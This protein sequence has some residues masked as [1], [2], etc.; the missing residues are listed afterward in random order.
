MMSSWLFE[1]SRGWIWK[2]ENW[3]GKKPELW[4]SLAPGDWGRGQETLEISWGRG[5]LLLEVTPSLAFAGPGQLESLREGDV[6]LSGFTAL[7]SPTRPSL[8]QRIR[9]QHWA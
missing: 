4:E 6:G 7:I 3:S 2:A 9:T 1:G 8:W 5:W